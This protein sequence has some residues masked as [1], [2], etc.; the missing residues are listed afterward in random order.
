MV[1]ERKYAPPMIDDGSLHVFTLGKAVEFATAYALQP[2]AEWSVD[3]ASKYIKSINQTIMRGGYGTGQFDN[4]ASRQANKDVDIV[5][6]FKDV[7][8]TEALVRASFNTG[9]TV[10]FNT[11]GNFWKCS[12]AYT[13]LMTQE[14]IDKY[15]TLGKLGQEERKGSD[16]HK[17]LHDDTWQQWDKYLKCAAYVMANNLTTDDAFIVSLYVHNLPIR[18]NYGKVKLVYGTRAAHVGLDE[19]NDNFYQIRDNTLVLNRYKTANG[20]SYTSRLNP[21]CVTILKERLKVTRGHARPMW[22]FSKKRD[23]E[24]ARG[25]MSDDVDKA[26]QRIGKL[27]GVTWNREVD[28]PGTKM[29]GIGINSLRHSVVTHY[30]SSPA[31]GVAQKKELANIMHSSMGAHMGVYNRIRAAAG[32]VGTDV[33]CPSCNENFMWYAHLPCGNSR[34]RDGDNPTDG[35]DRVRRAVGVRGARLPVTPDWADNYSPPQTASATR[36]ALMAATLAARPTPSVTTSGMTTRSNK[37]RR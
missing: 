37:R 23:A 12:N 21:N 32:A 13:R 16:G 28:I 4:A 18:D 24:V 9:T 1:R 8:K 3:T 5:K 26:F 22:L 2:R 31:F 25:T 19:K 34:T 30:Y 7:V 33:W 17:V 6:I 11:L 29:K 27:A 10:V 15:S 14:V 36:A 35:P 20:T